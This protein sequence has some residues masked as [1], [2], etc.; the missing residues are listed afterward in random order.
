MAA[1]TKPPIKSS[2]STSA[3]QCPMLN[4]TNYTV[5]TLRM[6]TTLRVHKAWV[7]IDPGTDDEEK[8][9]VATA[10]LYQSIPENLILQIGEQDTPKAIWEAIKSLNQGAERVKEARLQT[11]MSEFERLKMND[12]DTIDS[13]S[14]KLLEIASIA[15]SLGQPLE[16]SKL[17][18]KFLN[19]LP[20]SKFIHLIAS[21]EQV[22]DLNK[23]SFEDLKLSKH[24]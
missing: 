1:E 13:F 21:L 24:V 17:V 11:L 6:K 9:D 14:G 20:S 19:S 23:T 3:V 5:W 4:S 10:L 18:K 22:L 7:A 8:N 16:A 15:A 2:T 12:S